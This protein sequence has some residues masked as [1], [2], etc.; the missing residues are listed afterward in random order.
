MKHMTPI[1]ANVI[2]P[3]LFLESRLLSIWVILAGLLVE[4]FFV[5]RI[6]E[7]GAK[8]SVLADV[9]MNAAST[10]LGIVLIPAVGFVVALF[11]GELFG[12]FSPITWG[13]TFLAAVFINAL[14][15][16]LVLWKGFKQSIG[17]KEFWW[18]WFANALSVGIAFGSFLIIPIKD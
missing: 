17:K 4:Y 1:L 9:V 10:L 11:P 18:L 15:E 13:F 5:W 16:S 6:T 12:T 7:L 2:W 3:A 14:I 8:R